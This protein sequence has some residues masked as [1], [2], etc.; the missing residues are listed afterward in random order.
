MPPVFAV[1][2]ESATVCRSPGR[3]PTLWS[4]ILF[5]LSD[6]QPGWID[7][8]GGSNNSGSDVPGPHSLTKAVELEENAYF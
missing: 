4:G 8:G 6:F 7:P 2:I 1:P 3:L 5:Q